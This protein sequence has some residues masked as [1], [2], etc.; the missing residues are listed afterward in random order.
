MGLGQFRLGRISTDFVPYP[1]PLQGFEAGFAS[2]PPEDSCKY[3]LK[4]RASYIELAAGLYC[5]GEWMQI[6]C[7][8]LPRECCS[9]IC[10][11]KGPCPQIVYTLAAKYLYRFTLSPMYILL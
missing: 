5:V 4:Y 7:L 11:P 3:A 8:L 10:I 9:R 6:V 1:S 2:C